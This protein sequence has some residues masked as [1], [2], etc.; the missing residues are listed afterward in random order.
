MEAVQGQ[1]TSQE[2]VSKYEPERF[3]AIFALL[4]TEMDLRRP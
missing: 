3:Q 1:I 4:E 2:Q